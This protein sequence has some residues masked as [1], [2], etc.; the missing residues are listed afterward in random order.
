[1]KKLPKNHPDYQSIV[2]CHQSFHEINNFNN[3]LM[4]KIEDQEKKV[5]LDKLFG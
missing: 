3:E 5:K 2:S 4:K 1:M